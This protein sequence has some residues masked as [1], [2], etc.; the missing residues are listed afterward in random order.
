MASTYT[1]KLNLAKPAHGDVDWHIPVNGNWDKI[2]TELDKALKISGTTIDADKDWNGKRITN[3]GGISGAAFTPNVADMV[4][5]HRPDPN[6]NT[7]NIVA[8][9]LS[10]V[11]TYSTSFVL[12]KT[13]PPAPATGYV[14]DAT[15]AVKVS[16]EIYSGDPDP[17]YQAAVEIRVGGEVRGGP[18]YGPSG[19]YVERSV[20]VEVQPGEVLTIWLRTGNPNQPGK[21]RNVK[22]YSMRHPLLA[23]G[24]AW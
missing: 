1:P 5:I 9:D 20:D 23:P 15:S 13:L 16:F 14:E 12:A 8:S 3:I 4:F 18:I 21:V 10:E 11:S 2:D 17:G 24:V 19:S 6:K 22:I 7:G